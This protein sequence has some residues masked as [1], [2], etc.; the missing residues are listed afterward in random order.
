MDRVVT[1]EKSVYRFPKT[2]KNGRVSE[3]VLSLF[4]FYFVLPFWL[5]LLLQ[6]P[7]LSY[8]VLVFLIL[9]LSLG[10]FSLSL[11]DDYHH[12]HSGWLHPLLITLFAT[13]SLYDTR[14]FG[15]FV[16][17][18]CCGIVVVL[19]SSFC[20]YWRILNS[21]NHLEHLPACQPA[22]CCLCHRPAMMRMMIIPEAGW[23]VGN[24]FLWGSAAT[25]EECNDGGK[26]VPSNSRDHQ[27]SEETNNH[28]HHHRTH[29][30]K[31][32]NTFLLFV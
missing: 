22:C 13:R 9:V 31:N 5:L 4:R 26:R 16:V 1:T 14:S 20:F 6:L 28:Y 7:G 8:F 19:Y 3:T 23:L 10:N 29:W 2:E 11:C 32:Q 25:I 27:R 15:C 17:H 18:H 24:V 21:S 12:H 30:H